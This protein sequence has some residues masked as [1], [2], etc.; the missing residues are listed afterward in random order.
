ML[1]GR[2]ISVTKLLALPRPRDPA[3]GG[4]AASAIGWMRKAPPPER[5]RH[6]A[7]GAQGRQEQFEIFGA[8]QRPLGH[9]RHLALHRRVDDEGPPG[10]PRRILDEGAD[11]GIAEVDDMLREDRRQRRRQQ[12]REGE[13]GALHRPLPGRSVITRPSRSTCS[14]RPAPRPAPSPW[15]A[16]APR[17]LDPAAVD[18]DDDVARRR[19]RAARK[20]SPFPCGAHGHAGQL[21]AVHP[22]RHADL[23]RIELRGRNGP[24]ARLDR[25]AGLDDRRR[26]ERRAPARRA[27]P[28]SPASATGP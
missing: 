2:K 4:G 23:V 3:A 5:H 10:H 11:V 13:Q 21:G 1:R 18:R 7:V 25:G 9:H 20:P 22:R 12:Q 15:P 24:A 16:P 17:E 14:G 19:G 28:P 26:R 8:R 6:Q 27:E